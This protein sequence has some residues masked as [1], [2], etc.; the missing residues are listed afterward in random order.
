MFFMYVCNHSWNLGLYTTDQ[1][2]PVVLEK[3]INTACSI[4]VARNVWI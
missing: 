1:I 4:S 2:T 3:Q